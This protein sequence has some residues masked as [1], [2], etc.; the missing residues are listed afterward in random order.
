[1][2]Q[3]RSLVCL[4]AILGYK[5]S[6]KASW[7]TPWIVRGSSKRKPSGDS[8]SRREMPAI[9]GFGYGEAHLQ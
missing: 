1:V 2:G 6:P 9:P 4:E 3:I 7:I 5:S 8:R